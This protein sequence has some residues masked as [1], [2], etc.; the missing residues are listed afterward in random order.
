MGLRA[1]DTAE[2]VFDD[3]AID[4]AQRLGA[5]GEGFKIAMMSLDN[6]R[7]GVGA[8]AVGIAQGAFEEAVHYAQERR[9][10]DQPLVDFQAVQFMLADMKTQARRGAASRPPRGLA[11]GPG[12]APHQGGGHGQA[13]R[14]A[15][16]PTRSATPA[17]QIHGGYGYIKE[18]PVERLLPR[19]PRSPRSTRG[20][21]RCSG[22]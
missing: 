3:C 22:S 12:P 2:L 8:Q 4:A 17:L 5:E 7:I 10:F 1:S 15:A 11:E 16:S 21:R 19:R 6:G 13:L 18:Y 20:R 9:Q 14:L